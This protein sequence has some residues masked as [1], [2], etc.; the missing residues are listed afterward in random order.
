MKLRTYTVEECDSR[1][2]EF[3]ELTELCDEAISLVD[4]ILDR[5]Y[6]S[7]H[8]MEARTAIIRVRATAQRAELAWIDR[9][10]AS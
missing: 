10:P 6:G 7:D 2:A 9:R 8:A 1:I 4:C 3:Q 5:T